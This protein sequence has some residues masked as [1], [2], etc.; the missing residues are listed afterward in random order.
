MTELPP[1]DDP[2]TKAMRTGNTPNAEPIRMRTL[3]LLRW[4]SITGQMAAVVVAW[5]MGVGFVKTPV[6]LLIAA[7][8]LM[9]IWL[10]FCPPKRTSPN[11]AVLQ[12]S[13]DLVQ[14]SALMALS[15]AVAACG[16]GTRY[17]ALDAPATPERVLAA[18]QRQRDV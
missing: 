2:L 18:V 17:P 10:F 11:R 13:F 5:C 1:A 4:F 15:D 8:I 6:I 14:I 9:N 7:S 3:V 12:L 16:D